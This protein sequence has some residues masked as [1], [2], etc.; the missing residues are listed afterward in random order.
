MDK[1]QILLELNLLGYSID[2]NTVGESKH[3]MLHSTTAV[4]D[5]KLPRCYSLEYSN[6]EIKIDCIKDILNWSGLRVVEKLD[7]V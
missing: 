7:Y 5:Y 6:Y 1:N 4:E 3:V 2:I